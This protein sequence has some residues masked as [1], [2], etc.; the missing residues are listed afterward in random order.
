MKRVNMMTQ[1]IHMM[2]K[3]HGGR[4]QMGCVVNLEK[5]SIGTDYQMY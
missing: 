2:K 5:E 4:L 1:I 3:I